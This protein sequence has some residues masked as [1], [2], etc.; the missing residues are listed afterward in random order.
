MKRHLFMLSS[1]AV[2]QKKIGSKSLEFIKKLITLGANL[3]HP[4]VNITIRK[5]LKM[6]LN[7]EQFLALETLAEGIRP[8]PLSKY[9]IES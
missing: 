1:K 7:V 5:F 6:R 4:L 3:D 9:D 2:S 8:I